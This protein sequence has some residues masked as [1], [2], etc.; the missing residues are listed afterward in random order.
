[1][2]VKIHIWRSTT[3]TTLPQDTTPPRPP[4]P[5]T[6]DEEDFPVPQ[7]NQPIMMAAHALHMEAKQWSSKDNEIIAAAKKMALLMAKLSQL[8]RGEGGTKRDL[9]ATAKSIAASSEEVTRLARK[10]AGECTDKKM[11]T[12]RLQLII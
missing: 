5:E 12:V 7:A 2:H 3:Q 6:D 1:M 11:R 10:L 8:V 9:I 4:P